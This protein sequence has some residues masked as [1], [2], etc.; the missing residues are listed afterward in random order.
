MTE[1]ETTHAARIVAQFTRWAEPFADLPVHAEAESMAQTLAACAITP[2][3]SVL[4]V[5]CGPGIVACALAQAGAQVTGIDVTPAMLAQGRQR[6]ERMGVAVTYHCADGQNLPFEES[7]FER[8]VTR[9]SFHHLLQPAKVL[10]EMVRV[11][12]PGGLVIV[13]DATPAPECQHAYDKAE[14]LRDPSHTSALTVPQMLALGRQ[15][16]LEPVQTTQYHLESC[17]CDQVAPEDWQALHA[18]FT[19]DIASGQNRLGMGAWLAEDGIRFYFP[20]SIMV[21]RKP[22]LGAVQSVA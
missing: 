15:A 18:L 21:W 10:A 17:L 3:M 2:G 13:I 14:T 9:Y 19:Q 4:D 8:V 5:A 6:A 7:C 12:R 11:C 22:T 1:P 20:I 16:G